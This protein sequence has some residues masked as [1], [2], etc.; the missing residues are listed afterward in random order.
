MSLLLELAHHVWD[1]R[2]L[3]L[4]SW[5]EQIHVTNPTTRRG[6]PGYPIKERAIDFYLV[7][8]ILSHRKDAA[9][10]INKNTPAGFFLQPTLSR[11]PTDD[12]LFELFAATLVM[13]HRLRPY[14]EYI[15]CS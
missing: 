10:I 6:R 1:L 3:S 7:Y 8:P 12:T 13:T 15:I 11:S 2:S 4:R 5:C 14:Y 9:I